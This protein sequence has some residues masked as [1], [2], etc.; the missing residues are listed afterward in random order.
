MVKKCVVIWAWATHQVQWGAHSGHRASVWIRLS[1]KAALSYR[2]VFKMAHS[3]DKDG[4][5][6]WVKPCFKHL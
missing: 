4:Q 3:L 5:Q 1:T 2:K 6:H